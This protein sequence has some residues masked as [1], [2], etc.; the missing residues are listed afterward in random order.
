VAAAPAL[1]LAEFSHHRTLLVVDEMHHLPALAETDPVA[2]AQPAE[3]EKIRR[4]CRPG[5]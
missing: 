5:L 4:A 2:A 3:G 1:H